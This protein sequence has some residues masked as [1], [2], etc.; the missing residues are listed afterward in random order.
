MT[1]VSDTPLGLGLNPLDDRPAEVKTVTDEEPAEKPK[2]F[3]KY[4][5]KVMQEPALDDE[6]GS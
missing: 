1:K 5:P 2:T 4:V 3:E 6:T